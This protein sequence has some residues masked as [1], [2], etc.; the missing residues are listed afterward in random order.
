MTKIIIQKPNTIILWAYLFIVLSICSFINLPSFLLVL[1]VCVIMSFFISKGLMLLADKLLPCAKNTEL[2]PY[3]TQRTYRIF[4]LISFEVF[5]LYFIAFY[6][7]GFAADCIE[8]YN[9]VAIG[10]YSDWHPAWHTIMFYSVPLALTGGRSASIVLFQ[11]AYFSLILG[12]MAQSIYQ[13]AGR[14][15][16]I[17]STTCIL[18]FPV[19]GCIA[20]FPLK[21]TAMAIT[22][23]WSMVCVTKIYYTDGQWAEKR[24]R[25]LLVA[26]LLANATLFR[27]NAVLFTLPMVFAL[28]FW[29]RRGIMAGI[30]NTVL[31]RYFYNKS[32]GVFFFE[33]NKT[34]E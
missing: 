23:L 6:L 27:H 32:S 25:T 34:R 16:A 26:V 15:A 20:M 4:F 7:G 13:F 8:Q 2:T 19:T 18:L 5:C 28:F 11:I 12:Y 30:G 33:C 9:Q 3:K 1:P 17:I 10:R 31:R 21:D 14:K 24:G 29:L 22:I